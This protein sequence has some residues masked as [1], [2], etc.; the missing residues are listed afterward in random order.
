MGGSEDE[1]SLLSTDSWVR[2]LGFVRVT[3]E[4]L[5]MNCGDLSEIMHKNPCNKNELQTEQVILALQL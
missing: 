1:E 4:L 3:E 2:D 5:F